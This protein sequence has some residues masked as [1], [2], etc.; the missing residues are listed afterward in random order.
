MAKASVAIS[1]VA[2]AAKARRISTMSRWKE[3]GR[4]VCKSKRLVTKINKAYTISAP[5]IVRL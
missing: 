4:M 1:C 5:I 3:R 2:E